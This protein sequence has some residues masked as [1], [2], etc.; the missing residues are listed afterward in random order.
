[1][2]IIHRDELC[3]TFHEAR[4][5]SDVAGQAIELGDHEHGLPPPAQIESGD[6]LRP[7]ILPAAFNLGEFLDQ[8]APAGDIAG[9]GRPLGIKAKAALSLP[10][11]GNTVIG[12]EL[13]HAVHSN[14]DV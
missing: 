7:V 12:D 6:E 5:K 8:L 14:T 2:G 4:D 13:G 3:P 1:M 11:G 9:N 10:G